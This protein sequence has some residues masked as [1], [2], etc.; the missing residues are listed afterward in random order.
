MHVS[1][2]S[3][4]VINLEYSSDTETCEDELHDQ[5]SKLDFV[6]YYCNECVHLLQLDVKMNKRSM[7]QLLLC[8]RMNTLFTKFGDVNVSS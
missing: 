4:A 5:D 8:V 2:K 1:Y 6:S 3:G 7:I